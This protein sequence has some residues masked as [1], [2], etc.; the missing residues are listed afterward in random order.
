MRRAV[1]DEPPTEWEKWHTQHCLN[2]VRQM[3]LCE[4]GTRLEPVFAAEENGKMGLKVDG[5]GV[6]HVCRDW[7]LLHDAVNENFRQWPDELY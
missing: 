4:A 2:Y 1:I 7:S 6:D 5:L 3:L